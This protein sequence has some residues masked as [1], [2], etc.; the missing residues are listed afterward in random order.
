MWAAMGSNHGLLDFI[1]LLT[2]SVISHDKC[3]ILG[4]KMLKN[5]VIFGDICEALGY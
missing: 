3:G 1:I 4:Y 2:N 5:F